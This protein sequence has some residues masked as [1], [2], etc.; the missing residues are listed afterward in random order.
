MPTAPFEQCTFTILRV[1]SFVYILTAKMADRK[2]PC[3]IAAHCSLSQW[4]PFTCDIQSNCRC[5]GLGTD[6]V[7]LIYRCDVNRVRR[8]WLETG[9]ILR[10]LPAG[11]VGNW[12]L[13]WRCNLTALT[14]VGQF[15]RQWVPW[16]T[17]IMLPCNCQ[18]L[19]TMWNDSETKHWVLICGEQIK[20][21]YR[22]WQL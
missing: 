8:K 13:Y 9:Q 11:G 17:R 16:N 22:K 19:R 6:Y 3:K 7:A 18:T 2:D 12:C 20:F 5:W 4:I 15:I 1:N 21:G 14:S 10:R